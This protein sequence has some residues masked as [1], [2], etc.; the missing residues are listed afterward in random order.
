M[1]LKRE[2]RGKGMRGLEA[3]KETMT[4]G[5]EYLAPPPPPLPPPSP[6]PPPSTP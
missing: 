1:G 3:L 6:S 2:G 4:W 5:K